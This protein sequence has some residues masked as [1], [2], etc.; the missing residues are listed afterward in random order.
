MPCEVVPRDEAAAAGLATWT[1]LRPAIV[2]ADERVFEHVGATWARL[3]NPRRGI[4]LTIRSSLPRTLAVGASRERARTRSRSSPPTAPSLGRDHDIAVGRM[5][6]LDPGEDADL[7]HDRGQR[8]SE[9]AYLAQCF[10]CRACA[11]WF[12]SCGAGRSMK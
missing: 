6:F 8:L 2:D 5:P 11:R 4:E 9:L 10:L 3:T 7:A 1:S 12:C